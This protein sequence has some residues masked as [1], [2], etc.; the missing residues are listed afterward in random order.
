M[1]FRG[2]FFPCVA[3]SCAAWHSLAPTSTSMSDF[4]GTLGVL[5][6]AGL[7]GMALSGAVCIQTY[8]YFKNSFHDPRYMKLLVACLWVL[9]AFDST[10][11]IHI[12]YHYM[13]TNYLNPRALSEPVWSLKIHVAFTS[14]SNFAIRT[15]FIERV[16][17]L[18]E[19]NIWLTAW[20]MTTSLASLVVGIVVS[21]KSFAIDSF[22][23]LSGLSVLFYLNFAMATGSDISLAMAMCIFLY[24]SR[25]GFQKTDSILTTLMLYTV[26]TCVVVAIDATL[27]LIMYILFPH[28]FIFLGFYLLI[29]KLYLN[30][31]LAS[32]NGRGKLRPEREDIPSIRRSQISVCQYAVES[33]SPVVDTSTAAY[34]D[35]LSDAV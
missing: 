18:S 12:L 7:F 24:R 21:I 17:F 5:L 29:S 28:T 19:R 34:R 31:Y 3:H 6:L 9:D 4:D 35:E 33:P 32:L 15:M 26:N 25:T 2:P 20:L 8:A 14:I 11:N 30:A 10:L 16:F 13:V 1:I 23:D 22:L 27:S